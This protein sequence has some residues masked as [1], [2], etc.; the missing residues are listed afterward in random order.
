MFSRPSGPAFKTLHV[1]TPIGQVRRSTAMARDEKKRKKKSTQ[2]RPDGDAIDEDVKIKKKNIKHKKP[3]L[4]TP[5]PVTVAAE[6][7]DLG[8]NKKAKK[9]K[10]KR[11]ARKENCNAREIDDVEHTGEK[12]SKE[13]KNEKNSLITDA[14]FA[15]A[16]FDPRFQRMPKR[17]SKVVIDSRFTRMFSDKNFDTSAAPVDKRG[18]RK[19]GKTVNPLLHY[20]LQQEGEEENHLVNEGSAKVQREE[21][22]PRSEVDVSVEEGEKGSDDDEEEQRSA[23]SSDDSGSTDDDDI[24]DDEYSVNS[25]ICRYLLASHEDTPVIDSETHRLAVVN[26]DWDHIKAVDLYVVMSSCLPKGGNILSVSIYP[27]E[28]GLKCMEIEAVNGPSGLFD[29][30]DEHSE[31]DSDIDNEKLR[32]YEL[33][34]LRYYY[35]VVICD[36]SASAS[37]IYK[38]LDGTEL[39]KTS[40]VFDL[41]FIPDS[42]EF[43]HPPRDVA[44]EAPTSYKEPAFQT[45]ALQHSNVKLTWEEDEP[46]RKKVLR[47]KFNPNQLDELNEYLASSSDS[48]EYD[49]NEVDDDE[50]N[51]A[52]ALPNEVKKRKGIEELRALLLSQN[53][54]DGDKSDDKDME[55]TFNTELE[56]LSKRILEKKDKKSETVWE[57]VL[58][59]RSEKKKA[60]KSRSKYSEDDSSD[61]DV[62]E[63]PDQTDDFFIDEPGDT[64]PKVGKKK[65]KA[66]SNKRGKDDRGRDD[67]RDLAREREASRA[68]LEL[69]LTDNQGPNTGP[70]GYNLKPK[71]VKGK[72]GKQV[73]HEEKLPDVDASNDPRFSA[74]LASH[75]YALDPTDPQYKRSAAFVRQRVER[76]KKGAG[77]IGTS[78][79]DFSVS[80]QDIDVLPGKE[81][82]PSSESLAQEKND[83]LSTVEHFLSAE[84][85]VESEFSICWVNSLYE[86]CRLITQGTRE[87]PSLH[88]GIASPRGCHC[89]PTPTESAAILR[90]YHR[91]AATAD[92]ILAVASVARPFVASFSRQPPVQSLLQSFLRTQFCLSLCIIF[93]IATF[94]G[95]HGE[96][97][98]RLSRI[99]SSNYFKSYRKRSVSFPS[100]LDR[101]QSGSPLNNKYAIK[102][103]LTKL[104]SS[105]LSFFCEEVRVHHGFPILSLAAAFIPPF[106]NKSSK[107]LANSFT[108]ESTSDQISGHVN[109]SHRKD[110]Y[111]GCATLAAPN[112]NWKGDAIEPKTGIKFPTFLEDNFSL[113]TKVL[114]GIGSRS[115]RIIKLK[116]LKLYAFGLYVHP[117]SICEKLGSKYASVPIEELKNHSDFFE[118]LLREDINMTVRLV[119]NCN[120]LKVN[121]VRD[122]FE[123]SLRTR[124][125]KMNPDTDYHC[126]RVFGS[127]FTQ[128]IALPAGTTID[129]RQTANGQLITEIGG[130][131]VGA[132]HS[133]DL[134]RAFFDMYIGDV[135][136]SLQAKEEFVPP[137]KIQVLN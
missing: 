46:E 76:Q 6:E 88:S 84:I 122:A 49:E 107:A 23:S 31:D 40:N 98:V 120:G 93:L 38:T 77:K 45:R 13:S 2:L 121:T 68:E 89:H 66:P 108:L 81:E 67:L 90:S 52:S 137:I 133:K 94:D 24:E 85:T 96:I 130:R 29:D 65:S 14:R 19:K 123:K 114:V 9:N 34:K 30:S 92:S 124:L 48:D 18:K 63:A 50:N 132:V 103:Y 134:C 70:K 41:R 7:E 80:G 86:K 16:H 109:Q 74:L 10:N 119:V 101:Y 95:S 8:D 71:K 117:H 126:L 118:D 62:E 110:Y 111:H 39:L 97:G 33:N 54:S 72:K 5:P 28:F 91:P 135:P 113:T 73:V 55:I 56:D 102:A 12:E 104:A 26:M 61:Y 129:F 106:D 116:S 105:T 87:R 75:L 11:K 83:F 131:Q 69:L 125:Q 112:I 27:S 53:D 128:D 57:A 35:A 4:P 99:W 64:E 42:M 36:S 115:M 43:K 17:E 22:P 20:Y 78:R 25:D 59:K 51:D 15:V 136:V 32:N 3:R 60:R 37:H 21:R 47:Q 44:T 100:L 79:E 1:N 127:Y 58:R 82:A